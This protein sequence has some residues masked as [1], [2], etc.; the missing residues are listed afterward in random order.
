MDLLAV[1]YHS[2]LFLGIH[3]C[4]EYFKERIGGCLLLRFLTEKVWWLR[5]RGLIIALLLEFAI[6]DFDL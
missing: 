5:V 2:F 6:V 1:K 3:I 4:Q